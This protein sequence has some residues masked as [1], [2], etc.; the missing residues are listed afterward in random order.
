[1]KFAEPSIRYLFLEMRFEGQVLAS[2][3]GLSRTKCT[4]CVSRY[5]SS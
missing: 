3:S 1:M 4:A 2:G 5:E